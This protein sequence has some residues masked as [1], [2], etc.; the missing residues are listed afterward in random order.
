MF[1]TASSPPLRGSFKL[2]ACLFVF[3]FKI[4]SL[5][6]SATIKALTDASAL[7]ERAQAGN[8]N[9]YIPVNATIYVPHCTNLQSWTRPIYNPEH[10]GLATTCF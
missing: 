7:L 10:C 8:R 4:N 2:F 6:L 5:A 3:L 1:G 9:P